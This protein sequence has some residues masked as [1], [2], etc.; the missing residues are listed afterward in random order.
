MNNN[1]KITNK[2]N[3]NSNAKTANDICAEGARALSEALKVNTTVATLGVECAAK[4][5]Q[6][7]ARTR[8]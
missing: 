4:N 7:Q 5:R 1:G 2:D 8:R 6:H 3:I